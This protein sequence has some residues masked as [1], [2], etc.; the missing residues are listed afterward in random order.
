M[1]ANDARSDQFY[2]L[3]IDCETVQIKSDFSAL[4][5]INTFHEGE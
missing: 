5:S 2:S 4:T 1:L 3:S